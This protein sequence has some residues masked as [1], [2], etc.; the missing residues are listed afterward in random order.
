[1]VMF[2]EERYVMTWAQQNIRKT[3]VNYNARTIDSIMMHPDAWSSVNQPT[4]RP[5]YL[6]YANLS[7]D[8]LEAVDRLMVWLGTPV[9]REFT[10]TC[11]REIN[12]EGKLEAKIKHLE[13]QVNNRC[14][15]KADRLKLIREEMAE[16]QDFVEDETFEKYLRKMYELIGE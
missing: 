12:E 9:G 6:D 15:T 2:N 10:K 7:V 1:M 8:E 16:L 13:W 3:Y 5:S 11:E 14:E 4:Y